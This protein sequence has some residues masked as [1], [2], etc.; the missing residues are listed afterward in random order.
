MPNWILTVFHSNSM[1]I[2][3]VGL[4]GA[5]IG[6]VTGWIVR[7]TWSHIEPKK[8]E[9][10]PLITDATDKPI[11]LFNEGHEGTHVYWDGRNFVYRENTTQPFKA[12]SVN[13]RCEELVGGLAF[14]QCKLRKDHEG[15]H[16]FPSRC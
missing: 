16:N 6:F 1:I 5:V 9:Q 10:C 4:I 8:I 15:P 14:V 13:T 2:L 7:P 11:C 3:A 12:T